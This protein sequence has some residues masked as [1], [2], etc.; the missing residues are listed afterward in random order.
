MLGA[1]VIAGDVPTDKSLSGISSTKLST[2]DSWHRC[3]ASVPLLGCTTVA[4]TV[5]NL[6][7]TG[8]HEISVFGGRSHGNMH[9]G[10]VDVESYAWQSAGKQLRNYRED[11][12]ETILILRVGAYVEAD[13][14]AFIGQ[15]RQEGQAVTRGGDQEGPLDVW[16]VDLGS[17]EIADDPFSA[18]SEAN[19]VDSETS[20]YVNRLYSP[21]DFRRLASDLMTGKCKSRPRGNEVR[22]GVW[23]EEGVQVARGARIVAPAYIGREVRIADDCLITR[24]S[25]VESWSHIDFGTAIEDSSI[26]TNTYVGIGLDLSQS[27]ADGDELLNL[28]HD[29]RLHI[30]DPVVMRRNQARGYQRERL[31]QAEASEMTL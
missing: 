4:R 2:W 14:A 15:H 28:R 26:L 16:A 13:F 10:V 17:F 22:P 18:L 7:Q 25:N 23:M 29:V 12:L 9:P 1:I 6:R 5:D 8:I 19:V 24:C 20:G 27:L 11:G 30:S 31:V 3:P 21:H